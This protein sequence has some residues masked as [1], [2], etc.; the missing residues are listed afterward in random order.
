[1]KESK[2]FENVAHSKTEM[3]ATKLEIIT[4]QANTNPTKKNLMHRAL[5]QRKI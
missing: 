2:F 1:M 4:M 3:R 5:T